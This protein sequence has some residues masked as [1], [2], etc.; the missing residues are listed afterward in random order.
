MCSTHLSFIILKMNEEDKSQDF[1][2]A[3]QTSH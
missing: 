2:S 3:Y 1:Y